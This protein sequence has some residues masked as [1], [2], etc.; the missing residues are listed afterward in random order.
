M[1]DGE[2]SE[3]SDPEWLVAFRNHVEFYLNTKSFGQTYN[4][5]ARTIR[6]ISLPYND[7]N[8]ETANLNNNVA[9]FGDQ[10]PA[11]DP[12]INPG[13]YEQPIVDSSQ[14]SQQYPINNDNA[15]ENISYN[16]HPSYP[17]QY[18]MPLEQQNYGLGEAHEGNRPPMFNPTS[19]NVPNLQPPPS[20]ETSDGKGGIS[21][22]G[23]L[24]TSPVH[25]A[26]PTYREPVPETPTISEAP[27]NYF[28][29]SVFQPQVSP[30]TVRTV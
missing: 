1:R 8:S 5:G 18:D 23:S 3:M 21:H 13:N 16:N 26:S 29:K 9:S 20:P 27:P 24:Q 11:Y 6:D 25:S 4:D 12:N 22:D 30:E 19:I 10:Q 15:L 2:I 14:F 28:G 7:N 17:S